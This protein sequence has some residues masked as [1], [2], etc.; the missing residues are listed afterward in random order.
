MK[1][2][3]VAV[4]LA[5]ALILTSGIILSGEAQAGVHLNVGINVGPPAYMFSAPPAVAYIPGTYVYYAPDVNVDVLFYGGYWYRPYEG[6]WYRARGY[7]GPWVFID[8]GRV[9]SPLLQLPPDYRRTVVVHERIPYGQLKKNWR[10][11]ERERYWDRHAGH[12]EPR[13]YKESRKEAKREY[14]EHRKEEKREHKEHGGD[15]DRY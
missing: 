11:W 15:R 5:V 4:V 1:I 8:G 13:H 3:T 7:N 6:R 12:D 10:H 9:P 14:K 2:R